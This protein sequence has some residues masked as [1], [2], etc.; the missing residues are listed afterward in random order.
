[1]GLFLLAIIS[2][3]GIASIISSP[4]AMASVS[5]SFPILTDTGN[6]GFAYKILRHV[7][8]LEKDDWCKLI[9]L[10]NQFSVEFN[11]GLVGLWGPNQSQLGRMHEALLH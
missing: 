5:I 3:L 11:L 6:Y 9:R 1:V 2:V 7:R 10:G 4:K 8:L